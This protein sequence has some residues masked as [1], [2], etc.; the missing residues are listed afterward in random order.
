MKVKLNAITDRS[1]VSTMVELLSIVADFDVGV[2]RTVHNATLT[3]PLPV[4]CAS[5]DARRAELTVVDVP[6]LASASPGAL[7]RVESARTLRLTGVGLAVRVDDVPS[8]VDVG[9]AGASL[10]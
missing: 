9:S 6:T 5:D 10:T 1:L 2:S 3:N 4:D 7:C 8:L